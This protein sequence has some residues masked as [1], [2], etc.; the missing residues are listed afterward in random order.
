MTKHQDIEHEEHTKF[1]AFVMVIRRKLSD[2]ATVA[3]FMPDGQRVL[4]EALSASL[5]TVGGGAPRYVEF[6]YTRNEADFWADIST[7]VELEIYLS[8]ILRRLGDLNKRNLAM[9]ARKR[10][11]MD[12]WE[13]MGAEDQQAFLKKVQPP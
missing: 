8:V 9:R 2:A 13:A 4:G 6:N 5:D 10:I 11:F 3:E 12:L 7:P 1:M